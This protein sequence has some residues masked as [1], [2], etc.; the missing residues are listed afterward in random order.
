MSLKYIWYGHG[1]SG[2]ETGGYKLLIDPYFTDNPAAS[3]TADA[4]EADYILVSHGHG[5]HVTDAVA[6][7]KRTGA[8]AIAN[9]EIATW[10]GNQ[11]VE[12]HPQHHDALRQSQNDDRRSREEHL[13]LYY[14]SKCLRVPDLL[15]NSCHRMSV[16]L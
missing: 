10:L 2:L 7:A 4:V 3:T 8:T 13:W 16:S 1:T 11:G 14:L 6:I 9:F 5:D 15:D 12:V